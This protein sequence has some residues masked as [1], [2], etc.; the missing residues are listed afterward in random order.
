MYVW[1]NIFPVRFSQG[2]IDK[3]GYKIIDDL[4]QQTQKAVDK[5]LYEEAF[6][7]EVKITN[8]LV[9]LTKGIDVYNIVIKSNSTSSPSKFKVNE[10]LELIK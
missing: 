7:L 9:E 8:T 3:Q 10:I 6:D 2:L 5:G 1:F 4:A